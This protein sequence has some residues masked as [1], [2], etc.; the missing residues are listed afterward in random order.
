MTDLRLKLASTLPAL[1]LQI[2]T[3]SLKAR[4]LPYF[5]GT[6]VAGAGIGISQIGTTY[7]I[8]WN[9]TEAGFS[10]FGMQLGAAADA[11][12]GRAL[13]GLSAQ[14]IITAAGL[15]TV[16]AIDA[17]IVLNKASPSVTPMQLPTVASRNSLALLIADFAGNGGDITITPATG[18]KIMGL[19]VDAPWVVG[20]GGA[21]LGGS[22]TLTPVVSVGWLVT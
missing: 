21:G 18:E 13:L 4:V 10:V 17:I 8:A 12:A 16:T 19:A 9:A 5:P 3:P 6:L 7:T 22:V 11:A 15:V 20:S 2:S 1:K 14:R